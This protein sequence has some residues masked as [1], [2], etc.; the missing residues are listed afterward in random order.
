MKRLIIISSPDSTAEDERLS[1][2]AVLLGAPTE[3]LRLEGDGRSTRELL[4]QVSPGPCCL[5]MHLATM[6]RIYHD[7]SPEITLPQ[8]LDDRFSNILVYGVPSAAGSNDALK[9]LTDGAI[10]AF[11]VHPIHPVEYSFPPT[12]R[13]FCAQLAGQSLVTRQER[14]AFAFEVR[15]DCGRVETIMSANEHPMFVRVGMPARDLY[16][17]ASGMP[18]L[19]KPLTPDVGLGEEVIPLVPPL[20]FLRRYFAESCWHC[21]EA[22][23][24]RLIIDDPTLTRKYG[25]LDFETLKASMR[26]LGYGTSIA[27]I[28]WNYWRSS[29]RSA[30]NVLSDGSNLSICIHGCDHTNHEFRSES[31][32]VLVRKATLGIHRMERLRNRVGVPFEDVMVFPQ[33]RFCKSAISALR[34][35]NYLAAVNSSCFPTDYAPNELTIADFLFPAITRFEGFPIFQRRYPRD[36]FLFSFDLFLGKLSLIVEH[37][38]YFRDHCKGIEEFIATLQRIEPKL[39]WPGLPEQM[40]KSNMRR[41]RHDGSFEIQFVTRR[42]RFTPREA[43]EGRHRLV[44]FE[45]DPTLI[46]RVLVD[47]ASVPFGFEKGYLAFELQAAPGQIKTIEV[48][49]RSASAAPVRS[50]GPAYNARV[51]LR[52]GLSEFRD[53][54]LSRHKRLLKVA[55][56]AARTLKATGNS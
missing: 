33:G 38:E 25:A 3:I 5:A 10:Q 11:T 41:R 29:R 50:F 13:E 53:G 31:A 4:G 34:S 49:D 24:A 36:L 21:N 2:L 22:P 39:S 16:L 20:I 27:F 26:R 7:I 48:V 18:D 30:A 56:R 23:T 35:A 40:M 32:S 14:R 17:L 52:R 45:P 46:E 51:L 8:L 12:A 6:D 37:H 28:P 42:F 44:K 43:E 47:G 19:R 9:S 54:T 1:E 55:T 15:S